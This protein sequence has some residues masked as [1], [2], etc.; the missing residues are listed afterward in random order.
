MASR[1][2]EVEHSVD[3]VVSE[4]GVS[5]DSRLLGQD[6]IILSLEVSNNL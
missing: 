3:T 1:S 2:D 6:I 5:L 4:S